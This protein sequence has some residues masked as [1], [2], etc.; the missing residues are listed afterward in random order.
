MSG[1]K[2][3]L[4]VTAT[5]VQKKSLVLEYLRF[6]LFV[7]FKFPPYRS[8]SSRERSQGSLKRRGKNIFCTL[9]VWRTNFF[10]DRMFTGF[11]GIPTLKE[12]RVTGDTVREIK[13]PRP[14]GCLRQTLS[15]CRQG[16]VFRRFFPILCFTWNMGGYAAGRFFG[17]FWFFP[18]DMWLTC[19]QSVPCRTSCGPAPHIFAETTT[20]IIFCYNL[21]FCCNW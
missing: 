18:G 14:S 4:K 7:V 5:F 1:R 9:K 2:A 16:P 20:F 10:G 21:V 6:R 12:N 13:N 17:G 8:E 11:F 15:A 19:G 3:P